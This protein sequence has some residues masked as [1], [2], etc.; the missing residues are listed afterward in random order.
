M[1]KILVSVS[2]LLCLLFQGI[3]LQ[4]Q[5][6]FTADLELIFRD[7]V[8][9]FVL[10][11]GDTI[12]AGFAVVNHGPDDIDTSNHVLYSMTEVPPNLFLIVQ[13]D[14]G[15]P[16]IDNGD[17]VDSRAVW[18]T[19][20]EDNDEEYTESYC[21]FLRTSEDADSFIYD[22]N[23]TNDTICFTV[24]YK[25]NTTSSINNISR[26]ASL[27]ISPNPATN[28]VNIPLDELKNQSAV[29]KV[30]AVDGMVIHEEQI[31]AKAAPRLSVDVSSWPK[32]IYFVNLQSDKVRRTGRFVVQ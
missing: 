32:G 9:N 6:T 7:G 25:A 19:N 23:L 2:A 21:Y 16:F 29:L 11:P 28:L 24:V 4:A 22:P 13:T 20:D 5:H 17:T 27:K 1:K 15:L 8:N 12:D 30:S 31:P 10:N 26:A 18:F 3:N 14:D